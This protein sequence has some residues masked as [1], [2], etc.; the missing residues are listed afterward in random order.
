MYIRTNENGRIVCMMESTFTDRHGKVYEQDVSGMTEVDLPDEI[1][2]LTMTNYIYK[3]GVITY[4]E[5]PDLIAER[6]RN[7]EAAERQEAL[8]T[9]PDAVAELSEAVS[10]NTGDSDALA[11]AV[12]ELSAIVS[13]LMAAK[14][15]SNG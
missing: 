12:A 3:D 8:E 14:E 2:A 6:E 5:D 10:S 4:D 15:A 1:T 7:E 9:I 13:D 11:D